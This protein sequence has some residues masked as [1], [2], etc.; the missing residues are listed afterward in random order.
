MHVVY[1]EGDPR[2]K[3]GVQKSDTGK[4]EQQKLCGL[5]SW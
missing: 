2:K 1:L 5:L 4:E 3:K